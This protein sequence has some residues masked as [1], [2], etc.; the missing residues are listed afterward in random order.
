[1]DCKVCVIGKYNPSTS[2]GACRQCP[3][4]KTTEAHGTIYESECID[5]PPAPASSASL[6]GQSGAIIGMVV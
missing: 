2:G 5:V 3:P 1:M 4:G 6:N